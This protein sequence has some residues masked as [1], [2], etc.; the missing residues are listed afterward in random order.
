MSGTVEGL[1]KV[2]NGAAV[3]LGEIERL[4][5]AGHINEMGALGSVFMVTKAL[6]NAASNEVCM[7]HS[8]PPL[9]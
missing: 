6:E 3:S 1:V 7:I 9:F 2:I 5:K 4:L 8:Q